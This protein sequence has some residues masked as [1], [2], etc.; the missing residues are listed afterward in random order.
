MEIIR[1]RDPKGC[2]RYG[3]IEGRT[4]GK[5]PKIGV[6]FFAHPGQVVWLKAARE[7]RYLETVQDYPITKARAHMAD[8]KRAH[9]RAEKRVAQRRRSLGLEAEEAQA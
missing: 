7:E 3:V 6:R 9:K 1:Y 8:A 2:Y 5:K 4:S